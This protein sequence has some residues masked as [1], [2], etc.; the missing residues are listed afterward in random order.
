MSRN[1]KDLLANLRPAPTPYHVPSWGVE[2]LIRA[3]TEAER[4]Q[5]SENESDDHSHDN[6]IKAVC[7]TA[8]VNPDGSS[9]YG[10]SE[11]FPDNLTFGGF[12]EIHS[13]VVR[14][15]LGTYEES[16]KS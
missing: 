7:K 12:S 4:K 11:D 15:T 3:L 9:V 1:I 2:V 14:L 5:F 6:R 8:M 10:D 13:A 16:K